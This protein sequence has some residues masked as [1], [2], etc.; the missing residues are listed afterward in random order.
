MPRRS[1]AWK[2]S[3]EISIS[4]GLPWLRAIPGIPVED[5]TSLQTALAGKVV[6][7]A[8]CGAFFACKRS[9]FNKLGGFSPAFGRAYWEDVDLGCRAKAL[10]MKTIVVPSVL[11][12]HEH[13]QTMDAVFG[14]VGK[15]RRMLRNQAVFLRRNLALLKPVTNYRLYLL[16]RIP[17]R[18]FSGDW[19]TIAPYLSL[20][21]GKRA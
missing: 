18:I 17:Q 2:T 15:R 21:F 4:R 19:C 13:S 7:A 5:L 6:E 12:R 8:L 1:G 16:L 10:G 3:Q 14:D 9:V 11:V 20:I